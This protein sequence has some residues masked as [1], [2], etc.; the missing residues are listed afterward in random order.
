MQ[1]LFHYLSPS[2]ALFIYSSDNTMQYY[3]P[4]KRF[5]PRLTGLVWLSHQ[6][7]LGTPDN[8]DRMS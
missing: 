7:R 8:L 2:L 1:M 5:H 6:A 3:A 4:P